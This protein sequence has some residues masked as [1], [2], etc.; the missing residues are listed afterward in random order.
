MEPKAKKAK[1]SEQRE[2]KYRWD[3]SDLYSSNEEW[4]KYKKKITQKMKQ[5]QSFRKTFT[6]SAQKLYETLD[7]Y[8]KVEKDFMRLYAY[9]TMQSDQDTRDSN[10]LGMKQE[11]SQMAAELRTLSSF[12]EPEI[13]SLSHKKLQQFFKEH[14]DLLLYSQFIDDIQR[15]K[16][17]TL[18]EKGETIIA[19]AGR[20]SDTAHEIFNILSN[21]ELP[22]PTINLSD[23]QEVRLDPTNY[24]LYR[25][26]KNR[27][28][29]KKV[30]DNFFETLRQFRRTFGT[31]LFSEIKKNIF[32]KNVRHYNSCLENA[33]NRNN[34]PTTVYHKLIENVNKYLPTLHRYLRLR[35]RMLD[36][37][38]L[39]YYDMYPSLVKDIDLQYTYDQAQDMIKNSL[40]ILGEEYR[41][42]IEMAFS[43]R[44][45]DVY[46]NPGKRSGAYM[47][48]IAY[49]VHPYI[50]LNYTGK[51]NDVSTLT[52]EL[53][54][55][56]H[57]YFSNKNQAYVNSHYPIFLAE[58]ASTVNEALLVDYA[59]KNIDSTDQRL[60][61]LGNY[62]D[63][64]RGT[65]FRQTQFAEYELKIHEVCEE[66]EALTGDDFSHIYI[67]MLKKY[68]DHERG[69]AFIDDLYG[70][71]WA[72]IPH[73]YY[74]FYVFQYSTSFTASQAIVQ[75]MLYQKPEI[76][77]RY[78][79]F[80]SNGCFD[81]AIP[82]LQKVGIDMTTD[83][84][85][86][87]TMERMNEIMDEIEGILEQRENKE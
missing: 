48:G 20:M 12:I 51:Y 21:A 54:H 60:S 75:K 68:F 69:T 33:L 57:S 28:D 87:L 35:K 14:P 38:E 77:K 4:K 82:T 47:D 2:D 52:H 31:Q 5:I 22:Y 61:L 36:I 40:E 53:G 73:F 81:Y 37:K 63:G 85:F 76:V 16:K 41:T 27:E 29:R 50:L 55:A 15:R 46:P 26:S 32:Y 42:G 56:M 23:G 58:V 8:H 84:P 30:F 25:T 62:L 79:D 1:N 66:G 10:S 43:Q 83:D 64:F 80:L 3:L 72:Y 17:H 59:L 11:M 19:E 78:I 45:I 71:E 24:A 9:A 34:I 65:L 13:I 39:H 6:S 44:W 49:D 7:F 67:E 70:V 74:N 18:D 86:V